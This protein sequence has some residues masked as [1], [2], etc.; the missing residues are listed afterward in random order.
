MV[1]VVPF[2]PFGAAGFKIN[3]PDL[4]HRHRLHGGGDFLCGL[5]GLQ[6]PPYLAGIY[7]RINGHAQAIGF[8]AGL[9]NTPGANV[10]KGVPNGLLVQLGFEHISFGA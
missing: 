7:T 3:G 1:G 2:S 5:S 6:L 9:F 8:L 10:P 4:A